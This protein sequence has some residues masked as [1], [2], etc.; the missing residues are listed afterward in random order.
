MCGW[1]DELTSKGSRVMQIRGGSPYVLVLPLS[2]VAGIVIPSRHS[3]CL[4]LAL[5][6][7]CSGQSLCPDCGSDIAV[8]LPSDSEMLPEL[9]GDRLD[10]D[11]D[12]RRGSY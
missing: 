11:T 1:L 9:A 2:T 3:A 12:S 6:P 7:L 5:L 10:T 4:S 8:A